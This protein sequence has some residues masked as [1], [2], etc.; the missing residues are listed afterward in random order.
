MNRW[1]KLPGSAG[2]TSSLVIVTTNPRLLGTALIPF[3]ASFGSGLETGAAAAALA[4]AIFCPSVMDDVAG[5]GLVV[6]LDDTQPQRASA[7]TRTM[8]LFMSFVCCEWSRG[9]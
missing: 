1:P 8:L 3:G 5:V 6:V 9:F 2:V 4:A 7:T